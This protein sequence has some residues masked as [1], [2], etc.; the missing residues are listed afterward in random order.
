MGNNP[1]LRADCGSVFHLSLAKIHAAVKGNTT[2]T[3]SIGIPVLQL[4]ESGKSF[5][6]HLSACLFI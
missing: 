2:C 3:E 1:H 5:Q 4:E 6:R